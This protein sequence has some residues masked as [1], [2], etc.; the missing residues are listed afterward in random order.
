MANPLLLTIVVI[1][2]YS[3]AHTPKHERTIAANKVAFIPP[4]QATNHSGI[5]GKKF[6]VDG[7]GSCLVSELSQFS[8]AEQGGGELMESSLAFISMLSQEQKRSNKAA[9]NKT[10]M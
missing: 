3:I 8:Q 9:D 1:V 2:S 6:Q 4:I 5:N 10:F 7:L